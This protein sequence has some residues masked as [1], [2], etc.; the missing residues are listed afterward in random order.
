[1]PS[2][3]SSAVLQAVHGSDMGVSSLPL[4]AAPRQQENLRFFVA[5]LLRNAGGVYSFHVQVVEPGADYKVS[6]RLRL[7]QA[8]EV[9]SVAISCGCGV[10][11][12]SGC[13][14]DIN[15]GLEHGRPSFWSA[16]FARYF[17]AFSGL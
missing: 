12:T 4:A 9:P 3:R 11:P 2:V 6:V 13:H 17:S 15:V 16:A 5:T 10:P 1:M 7:P 8:D 14:S